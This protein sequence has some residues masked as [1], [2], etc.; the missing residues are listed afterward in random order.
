VH[1]NEYQSIRKAQ[2][3]DVRAVFALVQR[4]VE[5][6]ELLKRTRADIERSIDDYFVFEVDKNPVA[7][8]ALHLYPTQKKAEIASIYVDPR[9]E[10]RGIGAK[11][12]KYAEDQARALGFETIYCLSTQ[13]FNFFINK[14]GFQPGSPDDLPPTRRDLYDR[15]GRKSQVLVK[16]L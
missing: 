8:G 3:K 10:N 16:P 6:D 12:L 15:S 7:C 14:G 4:G 5:A 2:K 13:A 1:A 9:H 11:L